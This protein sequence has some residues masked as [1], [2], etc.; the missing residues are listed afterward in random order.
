M[1]DAREEAIRDIHSST[2]QV[3]DYP[4][5][6]DEIHIKFSVPNCAEC[7]VEWPCMTISVLDDPSNLIDLD[8][9]D[10]ENG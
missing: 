10:A 5:S 3:W 2:L 4:A 7:R 9:L 8:K 6:G 1:D